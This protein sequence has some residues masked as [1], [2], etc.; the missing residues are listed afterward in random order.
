[1]KY[2]VIGAGSWGTTVASL[3][4]PYAPTVIWARREEV[5]KGIN[6]KH[7][8]KRYLKGYDLSPELVAT[9][10]LHAAVDRAIP[11]VP[12]CAVAP[13]GLDIQ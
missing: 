13:D 7:R 4:A 3:A 2:A 6:K 5:V 8:N 11:R 10:D 1:M 9:G 12:R